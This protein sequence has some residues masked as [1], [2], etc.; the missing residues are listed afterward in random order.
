[1]Q[2]RAAGFRSIVEKAEENDAGKLP[3]GF[4]PYD[5]RHTSATLLLAAGENAKVVAERL[6]HSTT[7]LTNDTYAHVLPT[8]Q[9]RAAEHLERVLYGAADEP[10]SVGKPLADRRTGRLVRLPRAA[11]A[12]AR[13]VVGFRFLAPVAQG[14]ERR[15]PKPCVAGSS[16]AGGTLRFREVRRLGRATFSES[17]A[18]E[19]RRAP[20]KSAKPGP[21][22][23]STK[24]CSIGAAAWFA[25]SGRQRTITDATALLER[26]AR[27][28]DQSVLGDDEFERL[29]REV[30]SPSIEHGSCADPTHPS[31][32][33]A[34]PRP[35]G[36]IL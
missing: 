6:G 30:L 19:R 32:R 9:E 20:P 31:L 11:R 24:S 22:A 2:R 13:D 17:S 4:R 14:I 29:N 33:S 36:S 28:R 35:P 7:V 10:F 21:S 27:L 34:L 26:L 3:E 5:L 8:M 18:E 1:M 12:T 25:G 23:R 15:F 16:P